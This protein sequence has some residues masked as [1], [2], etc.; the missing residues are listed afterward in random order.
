MEFTMKN[1]NKLKAKPKTAVSKPYDPA[2]ALK[3]KQRK[4][5]RE[6]LAAQIRAVRLVDTTGV[7]DWPKSAGVVFHKDV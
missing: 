7:I 5:A 4:E 2:R 1:N 3:K 6:R